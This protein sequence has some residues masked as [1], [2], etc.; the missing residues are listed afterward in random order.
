MAAAG[1]ETTGAGAARS[2]EAPSWLGHFGLAVDPF[3][4]DSGE[5]YYG[6]R[7]GVASLRLEQALGRQRGFIVVCGSAGTGKSVLLDSVL[8]RVELSALAKVSAAET[9]PTSV[10]D[11]LLRS[12]E[13]VAGQYGATRKRAALLALIDSARKSGRPIVCV[14][15]D[16]HRAS[17]SQLKDLFEAVNIT[18]DAHMVLQVVLVGRPKLRKTLEAATLASLSTRVTT[19]VDTTALTP[20]EVADYLSDRLELAGA[21]AIDAILPTPTMTAIAHYSRGVIALCNALTRTA[22]QRAAETGAPSVTAEHVDEAAE[23]CVRLIDETRPLS[24]LGSPR[25][26]IVSAAAVGLVGLALLVAGAQVNM[27]G[28]SDAPIEAAAVGHLPNVPA[29]IVADDLAAAD[30]VAQRRSPREEFLAGTPYEVEIEPPPRPNATGDDQSIEMMLEESELP[31][32]PGPPRPQPQQHPL[33]PPI[34]Q[35]QAPAQPGGAPTAAPIPAPMPAPTAPAVEPPAAEPARPYMSLQVGAFRELRSATAM[36]KKLSKLSP[37]V[38]IST[39][40]SGGEPLHRVRVGRF[41]TPEETLP[42]KQRLQSAGYPS[43]RVTEP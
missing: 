20:R 37:D 42:L 18:P 22:M 36:K 21:G 11:V 6:A 26:W 30:Q 2:A 4:D 31:P 3:R 1:T 29:P 17:T 33:M 8:A 41:D 10:L 39:I 9:T 12:R 27:I 43:F 34:S 5:F 40:H 13:P 14:I 32:A 19:R 16:A 23:L 28:S 15:E 25:V 38:Y 7:Y 24:A 35:R